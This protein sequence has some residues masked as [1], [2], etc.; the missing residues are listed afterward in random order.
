[1]SIS[2][3]RTVSS[4][5]WLE[6]QLRDPYVAA[7]RR[8][9]YRSRAAFKLAELD[10]RFR[11]LAAGA[12]VL[13]LGAAPG[14]WSQVAAERVGA[15]TVLGVVVAVDLLPLA[16]LP[17]VTALTLDAG[18]PE[19]EAAMREALGGPADVVL[20]DMAPNSTGHA[21]VDHLRVVGLVAAAADLATHLLRPGG[22]FV[23]KV[24][25]G[26][27]EGELLRR[28]KRSFATVRHAKPKASRVESAEVYLVAQGFRADRPA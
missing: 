20:S 1:M 6:R 15:K 23:A 14:G 21:G 2:G 13:D 18:L 12:R 5:R 28:L 9:G 25:Q 11:F 26:G 7:A 10:D 16:P 27:T 4:R 3:R 8:A 17:G 24:W 22:V 19:S